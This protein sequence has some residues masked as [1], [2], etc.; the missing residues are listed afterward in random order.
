[1]LKLVLPIA[2]A[3]LLLGASAVV[4]A[5]QP[6]EQP[7]EAVVDKFNDLLQVDTE[8]DSEDGLENEADDEKRDDKIESDD[9]EDDSLD[10]DGGAFIQNFLF[11]KRLSVNIKYFL[12][13][14]TG[15]FDL[16][17][18]EGIPGWRN[19]GNFCGPGYVSR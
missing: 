1:M 14:A 2:V 7:S 6:L 16:E 15:S 9:D 18:T 19:Y 5:P 4:A 12:F 8:A 13:A 11:C 3:L 10:S 17:D